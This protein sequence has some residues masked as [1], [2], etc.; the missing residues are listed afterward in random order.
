MALQLQLFRL[1]QEHAPQEALLR[2]T[3]GAISSLARLDRSVMPGSKDG[4]EHQHHRK[5]NRLQV[6]L[7]ISAFSIVFAF[8]HYW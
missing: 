5:R 3:T 4:Q 7:L 8:V 1:Q 2:E 6:G